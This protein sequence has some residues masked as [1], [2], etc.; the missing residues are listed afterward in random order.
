LIPFNIFRSHSES[1]AFKKSDES[2]RS[3]SLNFNS[4]PSDIQRDLLQFLADYPN[5]M[6]EGRQFVKGAP[7]SFQH[8]KPAITERTTFLFSDIMFISKKKVSRKSDSV[9]FVSLVIISL[10]EAHVLAL[11]DTEKMKNAIQIIYKNSGYSLAS[12]LKDTAAITQKEEWLKD[13]NH[14]INETKKLS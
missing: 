11:P 8:G 4:V 3:F 12:I 14:F 9:T 13:L 2:P 10:S 7:F 5:V 6:K 1:D